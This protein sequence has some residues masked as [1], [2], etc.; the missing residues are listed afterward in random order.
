MRDGDVRHLF[1]Y[2]AAPPCSSTSSD[3]SLE[4][5]SSDEEENSNNHSVLWAHNA[6][7]SVEEELSP[8][9]TNSDS[10]AEE[11]NETPEAVTSP[12]RLLIEDDN[13]GDDDSSDEVESQANGMPDATGSL[14]TGNVT[15]A[16][17]VV[18][19][20]PLSREELQLARMALRALGTYLTKAKPIKKQKKRKKLPVFK[21]PSSGHAQFAGDP[22]TLEP[23][24]V[25]MQLA[26]S[27]L[28]T[29]AAADKDNPKFINKLVDYFTKGSSVRHWFEAYAIRRRELKLKLSWNK[30]VAALR[31]DYG[32]RDQMEDH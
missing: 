19:Y 9:E 1:A 30:L 13:S 18:D 14:E 25:H 8:V 12:K 23:F 5:E 22:E 27:E 21:V 4:H 24:I 32:I 26:H 2:L 16:P 10:D 11:L 28:T 31:E 20:A 17:D 6:L 29:G 3:T 15:P 7:S